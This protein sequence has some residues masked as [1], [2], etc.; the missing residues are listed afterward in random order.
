MLLV[1]EVHLVRKAGLGDIADGDQEQGGEAIVI[2][3]GVARVAIAVVRR[4]F[5]GLIARPTS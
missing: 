1:G 2:A 4:K 3:C 5:G